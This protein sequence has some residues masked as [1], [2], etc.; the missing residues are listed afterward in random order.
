MSTVPKPRPSVFRITKN[1]HNILQGVA[2]PDQHVT[3]EDKAAVI[4]WITDNAQRYWLNEGGPLRSP[5]DGGANIIIVSE[6]A[7]LYIA[8]MYCITGYAEQLG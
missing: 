7:S 4:E 5:E 3:A 6:I 8:S 2:E 1:I